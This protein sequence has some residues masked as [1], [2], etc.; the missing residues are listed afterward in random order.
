M[1]NDLVMV[2]SYPLGCD[3]DLITYYILSWVCTIVVLG[4]GVCSSC[5][6]MAWLGAVRRGGFAR[7]CSLVLEMQLA[8]GLA[9]G[10]DKHFYYKLLQLA[11]GEG[12]F[13]LHVCNFL[14][15]CPCLLFFLYDQ[16]SDSSLHVG[17]LPL[18]CEDP[19]LFLEMTSFDAEAT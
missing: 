5:V 10:G 14:L 9:Y 1:M 11:V 17:S 8:C 15:Q 7:Q 3:N 19:P 2:E 16:L 6:A 12:V 4:V 18:S 13:V